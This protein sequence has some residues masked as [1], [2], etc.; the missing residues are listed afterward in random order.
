MFYYY[1]FDKIS[2]ENLALSPKLMASPYY[3]S[4]PEEVS[5]SGTLAIE[6]ENNGIG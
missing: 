6:V 1:D 3:M 2:D 5:E 4:P